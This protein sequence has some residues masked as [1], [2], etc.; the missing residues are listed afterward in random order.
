M[1]FKFKNGNTKVSVG[2]QQ[3]D[4]DSNGV[5]TVPSSLAPILQASFGNDI[6]SAAISEPTEIAQM[7]RE[8]LIE[9][10]VEHGRKQMTSATVEQ[11][12]AAAT[13]VMG[14]PVVAAADAN[15]E[16][17]EFGEMSREEL[18][19]WLRAHGVRAQPAHGT[20]KLRGMARRAAA[21]E[22][23]APSNSAAAEK[24]PAAPLPGQ[25][26]AADPLPPQTPPLSEP[27]AT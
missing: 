14:M 24:S 17:D 23:S 8:A 16:G 5:L 10:L 12:R 2:G 22:G 15:G 18:F 7:S 4:A 25:T 21:A 1:R 26:P 6:Q 11:L 20:D 19:E 13:N 3:F 9:L 27:G